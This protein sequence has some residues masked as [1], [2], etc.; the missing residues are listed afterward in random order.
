MNSWLRSK[1]FALGTVDVALVHLCCELKRDITVEDGLGF[2]H[3]QNGR[4]WYFVADPDDPWAALG[5]SIV[6]L[7]ETR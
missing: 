5:R 2:F 3:R 6:P 7:L 1:A 4:Q